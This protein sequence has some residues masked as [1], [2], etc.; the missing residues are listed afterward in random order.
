MH[1]YQPIPGVWPRYLLIT[2]RPFIST[3]EKLSKSHA[4]TIDVD[5]ILSSAVECVCKEGVTGRLLDD[6]ARWMLESQSLT[7][8]WME[9]DEIADAE[10]A[11]YA[12]LIGMR[13][14]LQQLGAYRN[15][16][17]P[18]FYKERRGPHSAL[19]QYQATPNG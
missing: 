11:V 19:L 1:L 6:A 8:T 12:T 2:V 5:A 10:G 15:G 4:F 16:W 17:L 18:Y 13:D 3:L 7:G 9:I 14:E